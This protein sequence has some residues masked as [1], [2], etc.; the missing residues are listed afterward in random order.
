M[1]LLKDCNIIGNVYD[2]PELIRSQKWCFIPYYPREHFYK[3]LYYE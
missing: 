3:T 1:S 2:N